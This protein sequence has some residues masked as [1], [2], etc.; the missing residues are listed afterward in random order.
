MALEQESEVVREALLD[1]RLLSS[2]SAEDAHLFRQLWVSRERSPTLD[3]LEALHALVK[4]HLAEARLEK[5]VLVQFSRADSLPC[6]SNNI[7]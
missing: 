5:I 1:P 6:L 4:G 7:Y 2:M 3:E